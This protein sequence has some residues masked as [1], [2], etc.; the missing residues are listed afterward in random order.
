MYICVTEVDAKT[1]IP[2][3]ESPQKTG[4]VMPSV[5]NLVVLWANQSEWPV[6]LRADGTYITPPKYYGTCDDDADIT[7]PGVLE[8]LTEEEWFKRKE[9]EMLARKPFPSWILIDD[10]WVP[11]LLRPADAIMNGGN[12]RY[13][14][15]EETLSWIAQAIP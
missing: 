12:V 11:P 10:K 14:W 15:D 6:K 1:K 2:C 8:V 9:Q 13:Q 5:K 7:I 3:T 4:P